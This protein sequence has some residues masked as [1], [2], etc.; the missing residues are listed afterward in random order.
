MIKIL[1]FASLREQLGCNQLSFDEGEYPP[2]LDQLKAQLAEKDDQWHEVMT[3]NRTL[4]AVNQTMTREDT[5][6]NPG[7]EIAFFPPVTGG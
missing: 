5:M 3:S 4:T 6:L 2:T 1:V 7:D